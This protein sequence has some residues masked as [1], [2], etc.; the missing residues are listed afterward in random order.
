MEN[1][2]TVK[3][4]S[5]RGCLFMIGGRLR[6]VPINYSGA[7]RA[8]EARLRRAPYLIKFGNPSIREILVIK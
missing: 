3:L 4:K 2:R 5:G 1:Y 8:R 6:E 7:P